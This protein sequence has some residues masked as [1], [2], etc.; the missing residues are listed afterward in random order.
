M[1]LNPNI[2][3]EKPGKGKKKMLLDPAMCCK[4]IHRNRTKNFLYKKP[5][6]L[7]KLTISFRIKKQ[8]WMQSHRKCAIFKSSFLGNYLT[9]MD[10]VWKPHLLDY[11]GSYLLSETKTFYMRSVA[12][13]Q[14]FSIFQN[15]LK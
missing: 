11:T 3:H 10:V 2:S 5:T 4:L 14:K 6:F 13:F 15:L 8:E 9:D 12:F 7:V 1:C